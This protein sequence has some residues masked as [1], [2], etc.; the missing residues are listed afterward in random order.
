MTRGLEELPENTEPLTCS[1]DM[2]NIL[3]SS[4][5]PST[6]TAIPSKCANDNV[7]IRRRVQDIVLLHQIYKLAA[8]FCQ[9][10]TWLVEMGPALMATVARLPWQERVAIASGYRA[11][12]WNEVQKT[13]HP[14]RRAGLVQSHVDALFHRVLAPFGGIE[15]EDA[16]AA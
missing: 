6:S 7:D 14:W 15:R 3:K 13:F 8:D 2:P 16:A 11:T 4:N 9:D 5:H 10:E 12:R 1:E